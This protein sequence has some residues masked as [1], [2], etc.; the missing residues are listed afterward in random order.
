MKGSYKLYVDNELVGTTSNTL[1]TF[2]KEAILRFLAKN[3]ADWASWMVLGTG[4]T[5]ST[6]GDT[7]LEF[8]VA[9]AETI[10]FVA[11][12]DG[13]KIVAKAEFGPS[14]VGKFNEIGM[15]DTGSN[16]LSTAYV[17]FD[18]NQYSVTSST[19]ETTNYRVGSNGWQISATSGNTTTAGMDGIFINLSD[20]SYE[21]DILF[22]YYADANASSVEIRLKNAEGGYIGY[23][24]VPTAGYNVESFTRND[25]VLSGALLS[26]DIV[27]V[28]VLVTASGGDTVFVADAISVSQEFS[29][30]LAKLISR[31]VIPEQVKVYGSTLRVEYELEMSF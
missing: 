8:E 14:V 23:T 18:P 2:A 5:P 17:D 9:G 28:D 11:D 21:D 29:A 20:L 15:Y 12:I 24:F 4:E 22:A 10:E 27:D 30:S 25:L 7:R 19:T 26:D 6:S 3:R 31:A 1:T 13:S 16:V